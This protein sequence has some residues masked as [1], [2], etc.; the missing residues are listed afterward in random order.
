MLRCVGHHTTCC[1]VVWATPPHV[2]AQLRRPNIGFR[3]SQ[4]RKER[5]LLVRAVG[6]DQVTNK[7]RIVRSQQVSD[8]MRDT[9][10]HTHMYSLHYLAGPLFVF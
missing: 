7:A 8:T 9:Q 10:K 1:G 6:D 3:Q 5:R 2:V 4:V